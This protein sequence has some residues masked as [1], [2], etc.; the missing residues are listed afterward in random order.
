MRSALEYAYAYY[1]NS[2]NVDDL[3]T[4]DGQYM[5]MDDD[6]FH[7]ESGGMSGRGARIGTEADAASANTYVTAKYIP[8][9]NTGSS[10]MLKLT[11]YSKSSDAFG[12]R[13]ETVHMS[14]AYVIN[15][16]S[17]KNRVTM[18]DI[19]MDTTVLSQNIQRDAIQIHAR[20]Y[21]GQDW[22]PFYYIWTYKDVSKMYYNNYGDKESTCYDV[23]KKYK[24]ASPDD[25]DYPGPTQAEQDAKNAVKKINTNEKNGNKDEPE[26]VWNLVATDNKHLGPASY[27]KSSDNGWYQTSFY[28]DKN[29][30]N[31][32]NLMITKKGKVMSEVYRGGT[33]MVTADGIQS[34]EM[35]HLWFLTSDDKNVYVEFL[36]NDLKY[37]MKSD[38]NGLDEL[39]D[40]YLIYVMN[41]KTTVHFK[42]K[43]IDDQNVTTTTKNPVITYITV[44]G[45]SIF[46]QSNAYLTQGLSFSRFAASADSNSELWGSK[47]P[48]YFS[49][50]TVP[51][52]HD[53][54]SFKYMM[55]E[56]CGWW[57]ANVPVGVTF[58]MHVNYYKEGSNTM[59]G[60]GLLNVEP[61]R[62]T[63]EAFVVADPSIP[64]KMLSRRTEASA[65]D[66]IGVDIN[67]Y[68]TVKYKTSEIGSVTAPRLDYKDGEATRPGR[69]LLHELI[70]QV[71]EDYHPDDYTEESYNVLLQKIDDGITLYNIYNYLSIQ[72]NDQHR[73]V[74]DVDKDYDDAIKAIKDAVKNLVLRGVDNNL[75]N[76][77]RLLVE[78]A[79]K[80]V[81]DQSKNHA[82]DTTYFSAF[83]K[84]Y[85]EPA[86]GQDPPTEAHTSMLR[87]SL[88]S[89]I[90]TAQLTPILL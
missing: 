45:S 18:T 53:K 9:S 62:T 40:R 42:A 81:T 31:Y 68:S 57:V 1:G 83:N 64:G 32:F 65:C 73:T 72:V 49:N 24:F 63:K 74:E 89:S 20:P 75:K 2:N 39:D 27:F 15:S 30:V 87:K 79:D 28:Y 3:Q 10:A 38:W 76:D 37:R 48:Y 35:F 23:E 12:N 11:A 46:S 6:W 19:D 59:A 86:E 84:D 43:G 69:R 90:Q 71:T 61:N 52:G 66:W 67:S 34:N 13:S 88:K 56:G 16:G 51:A 41:Q 33:G 21:P 82:Y 29:D 8:A 54:D 78:Q 36:K 26:G 80:I 5:I 44:G 25:P 17:A 70:V 55:Y 4:V 58:A 14:A 77:L 85:V 47:T 7:N 60:S 22:T 50:E